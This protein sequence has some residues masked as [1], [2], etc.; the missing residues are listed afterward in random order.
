MQAA[1]ENGMGSRWPDDMVPAPGFRLWIGERLAGHR[2][3]FSPGCSFGLVLW[4][5]CHGWATLDAATRTQ[6]GAA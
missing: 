3:R 5:P 4:V 2:D 1:N 6:G